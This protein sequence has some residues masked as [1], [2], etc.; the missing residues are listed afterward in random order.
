MTGV[1]E[2]VG[3]SARVLPPPDEPDVCERAVV[4]GAEDRRFEPVFEFEAEFE[5]I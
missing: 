4:S 5:A 3:S 2:L 1:V